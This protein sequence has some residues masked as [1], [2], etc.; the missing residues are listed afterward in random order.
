MKRLKMLMLK[1]VATR[2]CGDWHAIVEALKTART[3][4]PCWRIQMIADRAN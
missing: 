1:A 3:P 2:L 4:E